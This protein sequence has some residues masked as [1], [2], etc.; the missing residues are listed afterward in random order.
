M[1]A[2]ITGYC[3]TTAKGRRQSVLRR[4]I[5]GAAPF[6]AAMGVA[7]L[8]AAAQVGDWLS[9]GSGAVRATGIVFLAA[10]AVGGWTLRRPVIDARPIVAANAVFALWCLV[11]LALDGPNVAGTALLVVSALASAGTAVAEARLAAAR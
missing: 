3:E 5:L 1:A 6:D 10:A 2:A 4:L 9:I 7:C 11:V 8:A